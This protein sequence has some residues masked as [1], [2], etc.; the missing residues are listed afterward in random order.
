MLKPFRIR[1]LYG[2][3]HGVV[4]ITAPQYDATIVSQPDAAL[5]YLDDDDGEVIT[6]GSSFELG[7][8]LDEPALHDKPDTLS[9]PLDPDTRMHVFDIRH[10]AASL[11][12]WREHEAYSSKTLRKKSNASDSTAPLP[13]RRT[14]PDLGMWTT[15]EN[16]RPVYDRYVER[17][18][19]ECA[20][21][22]VHLVQRFSMRDDGPRSPVLNFE[23]ASS[24]SGNSQL[25]TASVGVSEDEN[26]SREVTKACVDFVEHTDAQSK[27]NRTPT[28]SEMNTSMNQSD[29]SYSAA[30]TER[31]S[32]MDTPNTTS[33]TGKVEPIRLDQIVTNALQGLDSH[34]GGFADF[35]QRTSNSFRDAADKTREADTSAVEGMLDGFRGILGEVGKIGRTMLQTLDTEATAIAKDIAASFAEELE[36]KNHGV[37]RRHD[38]EKCV[39]S[40]NCTYQVNRQAQAIISTL[41]SDVGNAIKPQDDATTSEQTAEKDSVNITSQRCL[42]DRLG[43]S[44][45]GG[46]DSNRPNAGD[47]H[48]LTPNRSILADAAVPLPRIQ[49]ERYRQQA[50]QVDLELFADSKAPPPPC[51]TKENTPA[52]TLPQT[53]R[54]QFTLEQPLPSRRF[55]PPTTVVSA[56]KAFPK[57]ATHM[58]NSILDLETSD[59]D[60][61]VRYPPL[62]TLRRARTV[63]ELNR[64]SMSPPRAVANTQTALSRYP[65]IDQLEKKREKKAPDAFTR[66]EEIRASWN[67]RDSIA[68]KSTVT[69]EEGNPEASGAEMAIKKAQQPVVE[70]AEDIDLPAKTAQA[71]NFLAPTEKHT[72]DDEL[73]QS[74]V[75]RSV[76]LSDPIP[77]SAQQLPGAWP[78]TSID[79]TISNPPPRNESSGAF[80]E[81]MTRNRPFSGP[82]PTLDTPTDVRPLSGQRPSGYRY[83]DPNRPLDLYRRP[84]QIGGLRRSQTV[85]AS[86]P[87]ARLTR[88]FDP[89]VPSVVGTSDLDARSSM[90]GF[91]PSVPLFPRETVELPRRSGTERQHRRRQHWSERFAAA[92]RPPFDPFAPEESSA[93]PRHQPPPPSFGPRPMRSVPQFH[94]GYDPN[95]WGM[96]S[97]A[98]H[99]T[100][101]LP[102]PRSKV[103]ECVAQLRGMGFG[104]SDPHEASRLNVYAG[105]A[106]GDVLQALDM[107]E[108]DRKASLETWRES[109]SS[110]SGGLI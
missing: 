6:V 53:S 66:L 23:T 75:K 13:E 21:P 84:D 39:P 109:K 60:F 10:T 51:G 40:T 74:S 9:Y 61:S 110:L 33:D 70:D 26:L 83:V 42:E 22:N 54:C 19:E 37:V 77:C 31:E 43:A 67:G 73:P 91:R 25:P 24:V 2:P 48:N 5:T 57:P 34:L 81:R 92:Y 3:E 102:P 79:N 12:T 30:C 104:A 8:R 1:H 87:A 55:G 35:L 14:Q 95:T 64:R 44:S 99:S 49:V 85:T 46:L 88:P 45:N 28:P 68:T 106:A 29:T 15:D 27:P 32:P 65:S 82:N 56:S 103:D 78:E 86:N 107:I 7:Q 97:P 69:K 100:T 36:N 52:S 80:F 71:S 96:A 47:Y 17:N 94:V 4:Q 16:G 63:G 50:E 20:Q 89:M 41:R 98:R 76:S 11:A 72:F 59:P 38:A 90:S 101:E 18:P 93:S 108:E 62:M 58:S 105:A